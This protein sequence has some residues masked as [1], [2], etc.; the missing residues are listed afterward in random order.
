MKILVYIRNCTNVYKLCLLAGMLI[1]TLQLKA[2]CTANYTFTVN[3][4]TRTVTFTNHST[5]GTTLYYSWNFG[6]GNYSSIANPIHQ[7][8]SSGYYL[9]CLTLWSFPDSCTKTFCDSIY[10]KG[11]NVCKADYTSWPDSLSTTKINFSGS[12]SNG[13]NL[14]FVWNFGD[15][16][17]TYNSTSSTAQH[18][19]TTAGTYL[20]CL[21]V[22]NMKDTLCT[23]MKC[24]SIHVYKPIIPC[25]AKLSMYKDTVPFSGKYIFYST[26]STGNNIMYRWNFGD[27]SP[28]YTTPALSVTHVYATSGKY[29]VCLTVF[30]SKDSTCNH[31][32]CDTIIVDKGK[33]MCKAKMIIYKDSISNKGIYNFYGQGSIGNG[34]TYLWSYGDG[35]PSIYSTNPNAQHTYTHTG[36]YRVC[37][38]IY[39]SKDSCEDMVCDSI[40]V[41]VRTVDCKADFEIFHT[42]SYFLSRVFSAKNSTGNNLLYTWDFDDGSLIQSFDYAMNWHDFSKQGSYKVCLTVRSKDDSTC[43][44]KKC[45]LLPLDT[46][47]CNAHFTYLVDS[48]DGGGGRK[49]IP[50]ISSQQYYYFWNFGDGQKSNQIQPYHYYV[51]PGLYYECLTIVNSLDSCSDTYCDSIYIPK[52]TGVISTLTK[53]PLIELFPNPIISTLNITIQSFQTDKYQFQ[54]KNTLGETM[55]VIDRKLNQ[56]ES[57]ISINTDNYPHGIYFIEIHH[58]QNVSVKRFNK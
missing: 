23:N 47:Y 16:S 32:V 5:G 31:S 20:V 45:I 53:Q 18:T 34:L 56:G 57:T 36:Y 13:N 49:F 43:Y 35:S 58:S 28:L 11:S 15:G 54:I 46:T 26:G 41:L 25:K 50:D 3:D 2:G 29:L 6:D 51:V 27:G 12:N 19:Y 48:L 24:D 40:F 21:T 30:N 42:S 37:L 52:L 14:K 9:V 39:S 55:E 38:S 33:V 17:P 44:D 1:I 8:T 7:Y 10:I 4:S 22:S